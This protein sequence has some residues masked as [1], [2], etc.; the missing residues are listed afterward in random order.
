M[1]RAD[2]RRPDRRVTSR[3]RRFLVVSGGSTELAYLAGLRRI[4]GER[5]V[6][7]TPRHRVLDPLGLVGYAARL[8]Q[9]VGDFTEVWCVADADQFDIAPA[10]REAARHGVELVVSVP[11][12]ELWL[13][14]HFEDCT[15]YLEGY[16]ATARRLCRHV[17][18]YDK[19]DLDFGDFATGV[20]AAVKRAKEL[21]P[22]GTRR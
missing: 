15:A 6:S 14:L 1:P 9:E 21:D 17:P 13:L 22:G 10:A 4:R 12:F 19:A 11:C 8:A 2:S 16:A 7:V 3:A 5:S 18:A 20:T